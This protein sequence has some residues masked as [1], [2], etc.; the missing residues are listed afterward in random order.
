MQGGGVRVC[1]MWVSERRKGE[2]IDT[3]LH[4]LVCIRNAPYWTA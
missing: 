1:A 3:K 2:L 4:T